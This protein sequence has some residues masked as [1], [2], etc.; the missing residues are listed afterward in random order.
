MT[1]NVAWAP[2]PWNGRLGC[3]YSPQHKTSHWRKAVA[4]CGTLDSLVGSLDGLVPLSGAPSHWV[5]TAGDRWRASFLHR[6][7]RTSH[8]TVWWYYVHNAS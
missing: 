1:W 8:R 2:T 7:I 4:F 6:T 3:I 5:D